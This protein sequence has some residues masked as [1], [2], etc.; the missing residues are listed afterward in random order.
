[1]RPERDT[2]RLTDSQ[3][4]VRRLITG[5]ART[6]K[7]KIPQVALSLDLLSEALYD[8]VCRTIFMWHDRVHN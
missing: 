5:G 6:A 2:L 7:E 4:A 8:D 3:S 1:M